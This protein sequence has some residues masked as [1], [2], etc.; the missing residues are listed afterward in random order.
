VLTP[1]P[2]AAVFT[3]RRIA[4]VGASERPGSVG[5]L[6][7]RNLDGFPGEVVPVGHSA[8]TVGGRP[9]VAS[10]RDIRGDVDLAVVAVPAPAVPGVLR[11]AA[12][13]GVRA[14]VVISGGFAETGRAG[15][16]LQREMMTAARNGGVR[17]VGPNCFGVQNGDLPLNASI[18]EGTPRSGGGISLVTQSGA[19]GMAVHSLG[20]D[21]H[22]GFAKIYAAGN[23]ADLT[24]AE[25]LRYLGGDPA[26]RTLCF[27]LESLPDG[28]EFYRSACAVTPEKPVIVARTGRSGAGRRAAVSHTAA[29]AGDERMWRAAF[30]RAGVIVARSGLEMLDAARVLSGQAAPAGPRAAVITNSGGTG[31]ELTD[32][33]ADEGIDVPELSAALRE[34]VRTLLPPFA[35][36]RNPVDITPVW[37][38]FAALYPTLVDLLA[39]SGEVDVVVPVLL[40]RAATE[41]VA[42]AVADAAT[43]LRDDGVTVPIVVCWVAPRAARA[44]A[45]LL[46]QAGVPCLDWPERTARAVGHAARYGTARTRVRPPPRDP[47]RPPGLPP[48]TDGP[49]DVEEAGL[50]LAEA[51][52]PTVPG[53]ICADAAA[54]EAAGAEFGYPCVA[55]VVH[56]AFVHKSRAGGVR[57]GLGD[58]TRLRAAAAEL[59]AL[60]PGARVLVQPQRSGIEVLVGGVRDPQFGPM[61]VAGLGGVFAEALDDIALGPA[62]LRRADAA[63]LLAGLRGHSVLTGAVG[64]EPVDE[65]ALCA[66]IGAVGDLLAAVPEVAELDLNPVLAS[67]QGAVVVDWR[68]LIDKAGQG[69]R[70][71][72]ADSSRGDAEMTPRGP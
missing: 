7:W 26:S 15:E 63:R 60:G 16:E 51:G 48:L 6:L 22:A 39:R 5:A 50:L 40:Q 59:L 62:P 33:L 17:V 3:P 14:A 53:R 45:D 31:V 2:L 55:K 20:V 10:L 34:R 42:R 64:A 13:K 29:L 37:R 68:L 32:L 11:D 72:A 24:D 65:D 49:M 28:R 52:I 54:T 1:D 67:A 27:F 57:T 18:A 61:V 47:D 44:G 23:K 71:A 4:L 56:A 21:E 19:Y 43:R 12:A 38:E 69:G 25:L 30:E 46:Q 36:P 8:A 66:L 35:S 70:E 58:A 9:T 41:P